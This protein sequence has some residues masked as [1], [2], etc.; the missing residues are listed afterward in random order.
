M[1]AVLNIFSDRI[2]QRRCP[3][4]FPPKRPLIATQWRG[5]K[6]E[7]NEGA[8]T[9]RPKLVAVNALWEIPVI[10]AGTGC[11]KRLDEG[12]RQGRV[13]RKQESWEG[14]FGGVDVTAGNNADV[15]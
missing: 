3:G 15:R 12:C 8:H 5:D 14:G 2:D 1:S 9:R 6:G 11:E 4:G 13:R 10:G 7:T